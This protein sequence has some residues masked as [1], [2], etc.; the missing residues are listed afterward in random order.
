MQNS[1]IGQTRDLERHLASF[2]LL[3]C[4]STKPSFQNHEIFTGSGTRLYIQAL[5][6]TAP[7]I[8]NTFLL[9]QRTLLLFP[10]F[11][12]CYHVSSP[13]LL[14]S[15]LPG[16]CSLILL[17]CS[18]YIL[19]YHGV[20]NFTHQ[21]AKKGQEPFLN[22]LPNWHFLTQWLGNEYVQMFKWILIYIHYLPF[23]YVYIIN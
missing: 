13:L 8:Y 16:R 21:F 7:S 10:A 6:P 11:C 12:S 1:I 5:I 15:T 4:H 17:H 3:L 22:Y 14:L 20:L 2:F 18:L 19:F 9:F 23:S